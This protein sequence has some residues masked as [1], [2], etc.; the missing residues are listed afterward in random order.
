MT[1]PIP[2][3]WFSWKC[4]YIAKK[5]RR[6]FRSCQGMNQILP[7]H[8]LTLPVFPKLAI[9]S[10]SIRW[11]N[12]QSRVVVKTLNRSQKICKM[13]RKTQWCP[14]RKW[15]SFQYHFMI[16]SHY[17]NS[18]W[19]VRKSDPIRRRT[20]KRAFPIMGILQSKHYSPY[21]CSQVY[22]CMDFPF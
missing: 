5:K 14:R 2:S 6:H 16:W 13:Y 9:K 15:L 1:C 7:S 18:A 3:N 19:P 4:S 8:I 11:H 21:R 12:G 10:I 17:T 20:L 22:V